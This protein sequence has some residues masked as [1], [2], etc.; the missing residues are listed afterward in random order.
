MTDADPS[1]PRT[2]LPIESS[3]LLSE[4]FG[5][6]EVTDLRHMVTSFAG[7]SGLTEARLE[8]FVLAVNE[9]ITN[10]VRHGG[11]RGW[12]RMW[13]EGPVLICEVSDNGRGISPERL[14][15]DRRPA[16]DTAG[17]WGLWLAKQ[18][19][20]EMIVETSETGTVVRISASA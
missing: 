12:L 15:D 2:V 14:G 17:G 13:C 18:L 9:L 8:D 7:R 11:G 1:R 5:P 10:A 3:L 20:D 16:P 4:A 6:A 19:S